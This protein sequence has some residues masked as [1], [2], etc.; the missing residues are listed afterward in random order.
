[1]RV[2][3]GVIGTTLSLIAVSSAAKEDEPSQPAA[4]AVQ[5]APALS[6]AGEGRRAYLKYNCYGCHGMGATGGMGPNI[7]HKEADEVS[8]AVLEGKEGGM[9]SFRGIVTPADVKNL[10]AYLRS[11]GTA[12]EPKFN[13]WWVDV[14]P[15]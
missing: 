5:A 15:K 8:E 12:N 9:R 4:P 11:I 6:P 7:V 1:M 14:P 13:D 10:A 2:L 3:L